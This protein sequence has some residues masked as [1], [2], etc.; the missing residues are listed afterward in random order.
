MGTSICS[1]FVPLYPL[2][3]VR[4]FAL[5]SHFFCKRLRFSYILQDFLFGIG[6]WIWAVEK[7]RSSHHASV[8]C[9]GNNNVKNSRIIL[10]AIRVLYSGHSL[11]L[12]SDHQKNE[13]TSLSTMGLNHFLR[14][15]Y[16]FTNFLTNHNVLC[17]KDEQTKFFLFG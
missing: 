3:L 12:Y 2:F 14:S 11:A 1:N 6:I 5:L 8:V 16:I 10:Q 17:K 9:V 7:L 13:P 15:N 4:D